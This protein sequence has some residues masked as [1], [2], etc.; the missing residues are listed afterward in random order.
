MAEQE[1]DIIGHLLDIERSASGVLAQ[2]QEEAEK[3]ISAA[4]AQADQSFKTQYDAI[5]ADE[6]KRL[7]SEMSA[8]A[9]KYDADV[10]AYKERLSSA[11]KD[12]PSFDRLLDKVL[13]AS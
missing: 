1:A 13:F 7:A 3:R 6:E 12:I 9:Q 5:V 8:A 10:A 11:A 4:R 2:A